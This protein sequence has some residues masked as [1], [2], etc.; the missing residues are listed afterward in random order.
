MIKEIIILGTG[1][2]SMEILNTIYDINDTE[3]VDTE[4]KCIGF[5]DDNYQSLNPEISGL[6]VLGPLIK[7]N[8][9]SD[10]YFI[11]GIGSPGNY[12]KKE[13]IIRKTGIAAERFETLI[14]PT[15]YISRLSEIGKG[16][17]ILQHVTVTTNVKIGEHVI[18]LP[19]SVISHD[20]VIGDYTCI[21]G[22]VC[23]SGEVNIGRSAYIGTNCSIKEKVRIGNFSM[24]GM[25]SVVVRDV[26]DNITVAGNPAMKL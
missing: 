13:D 25:G 21:A 23:I 11:N 9:Y 26:G 5:L 3:G 2:N 22:S 10:A 4:Y 20:A 18:I 8:E 7:A 14:H 24:T 12:D 16:T 17:V 6:K 15:A 1:G 19:N